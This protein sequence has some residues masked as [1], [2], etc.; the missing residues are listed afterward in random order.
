MLHKKTR[1]AF[2]RQT[3]CARSKMFFHGAYGTFHFADMA[4]GGGNFESGGAQGFTD[5]AE[6]MVTVHITDGVP[7]TI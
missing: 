3:V 2:K 1:E 5:T 6:L 4:V 7:D